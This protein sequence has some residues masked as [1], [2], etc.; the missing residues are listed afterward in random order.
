MALFHLSDLAGLPGQFS[1][2][3]TTMI[4]TETGSFHTVIP[5]WPAKARECGEL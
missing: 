3:I 4:T 5:L 1:N 2:V